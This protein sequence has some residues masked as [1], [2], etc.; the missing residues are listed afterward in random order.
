MGEVKALI[1]AGGVGK[2][3]RPITYYLQ[4]T[5]IPVGYSQKP[6][7]EYIIRLMHF[8]HIDDITLLVNHKARQIKSYFEDG[9]RFNVKIN[10][11]KDSEAL[12]GT[13]GSVIN[14]LKHRAFNNDDTILVYYGDILSNFN[15][16]TLI[17]FHNKK[18][19]AATVA[20]AS[21]F[22]VRVGLADLEEDNRIRGFIEKPQLEKPVSI[23]I[24]VFTGDALMESKVLA[25]KNETFDLMGDILPHLIRI[26]KSVYGYVSKAFWYDVGSIEAYEKLD[27][28][29][30]KEKMS[31]LF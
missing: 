24:L 31:F 10:Y 22:V 23:G 20:L 12:K 13:G 3:L 5:M 25:E 28:K 27:D 4:K 29:K 21:G 17:D 26:K 2:R 8:H 7:L 30:V 14:A 1:L 19:G 18:K 16:K 9:S 11:I 15:L 6:L